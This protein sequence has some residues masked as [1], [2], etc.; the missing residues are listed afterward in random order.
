MLLASGLIG[1]SIPWT[2]ILPLLILLGGACFLLLVG[3]LV[4]NWPRHG[5]AWFTGATAAGAL[6]ANCVQWNNLHSKVGR[7]IIANAI[8]IDRFSVLASITVLG[9][10]IFSSILMS[11]YL[12]RSQDDGPELFALF[13]TAAIG[14]IVMISANDLIVMFLGL[15]VL[16][17]SLYLLAASNR[18][19]EQSQE[20]GIKYFV[21]GGFASAFFLYGIAL[22]YGSTGSTQL[23]VDQSLPQGIAQALGSQV[24]VNG[25]DSLLL[26]GIGLLMI[27]LAF[28]V[29][30][31]PFHVWAPDVYEGAPTP[32]TAFMASV[33]KVAAFAALLRVLLV[34]L[35]Q[36]VD[37]WRPVVWALAIA[38]VFI[39]SV[40]AVVQTNVKR[41]LAYSSVSHAGFILVGVEAAAH[42]RGDGLASSMNYLTIYTVLV[43][44]SFAIVLAMSGQQDAD[45]ALTD[46]RGLAK[47]RPALALAFSIL[48]FA[49]AGVPFTSGFVAKFAIMKSAVDVGSYALAV[50]AMVAAVIGAFLYLRIVVSMWLEEPDS[51]EP[52]NVATPVV[53]VIVLA[54]AF[55]LVI[56]L[57]PDLLL[58]ATRLVRFA[59]R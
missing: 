23:F 12:Q 50:A 55:T 53:L 40:M 44:G 36:R 33:G 52:L 8:F 22:V 58:D 32:V 48:L 2:D 18:R 26:I 14:A 1:P 6:V 42:M 54:V 3:S 49:Q 39:G 5:Y 17:L 57:F 59:P 37:D 56:G 16:S 25:N 31:A 35:P 11:A 38:T 15:E 9:A 10:V 27:G 43:M 41:M 34:G 13:L 45:T 51:S 7:S 46:F 21:L 28:K 20:S 30:A 4:P 19:R 47:R 24:A 29:S